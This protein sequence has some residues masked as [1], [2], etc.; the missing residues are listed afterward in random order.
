MDE[1]GW[2]ECLEKRKTFVN[3]PVLTLPLQLCSGYL[4]YI[5]MYVHRY[6]AVVVVGR[7]GTSTH[8]HVGYESKTE[9]ILALYFCLIRKAVRKLFELGKR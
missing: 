3:F 4:R 2:R 9:S 5:H 8:Y 6:L 1:G 7:H